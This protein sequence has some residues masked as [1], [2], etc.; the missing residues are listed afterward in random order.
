MVD[1]PEFVEHTEMFLEIRRLDERIKNQ[2]DMILK[3]RN[4]FNCKNKRVFSTCFS[5]G[6]RRIELYGVIHG[7]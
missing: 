7:S 5:C 4:C 6:G 2:E 1:C 3:M